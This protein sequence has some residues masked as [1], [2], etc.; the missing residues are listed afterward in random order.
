L[1]DIIR[2]RKKSKK[3]LSEYSDDPNDAIELLHEKT[4]FSVG[5]VIKMIKEAIKDD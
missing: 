1:N 3:I 4:R 5:E 2:L